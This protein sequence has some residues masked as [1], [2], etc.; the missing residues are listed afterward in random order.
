M[1]PLSA[2]LS[3][4]LFCATQQRDLAA[5]NLATFLTTP[6]L[7]AAACVFAETVWEPF[8]DLV[9]GAN[10]T[11]GYRCVD[12]NARVGGSRPP[13][14]K[15]SAHVSGRA[16]D[17]VPTRVSLLEAMDLLQLSSVQF[18]KALVEGVA[19]ARWLHLQVAKPGTEPR[20][21]LL[22]TYGDHDPEGRLVYLDF[23]PGD[24]RARV[25]A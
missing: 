25:F 2:H 12:L 10:L 3:A 14:G 17:C 23:D 9:G 19:G 5:R 20:R 22:V 21:Q 13:L 11:S 1:T 8:L 4:E 16:G 24:P 18:D 6:D 7:V 15:L